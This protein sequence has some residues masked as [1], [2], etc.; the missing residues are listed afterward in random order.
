MGINATRICRTS[1]HPADSSRPERYFEFSCLG[2]A[3]NSPPRP[4]PP[5]PRRPQCPELVEADMGVVLRW[6]AFDPYPAAGDWVD[7][8]HRDDR[9]RPRLP[10]KGSGRW[11]RACHHDDV[12]LRADQLLRGR[13]YPIDVTAVA[14]R[15]K[16]QPHVAAIGPTQVRKRLRERRDARLRR[17]IV[18]VGC[19]EHAD[20]SHPVALLRARRPA[21]TPPCYRAPR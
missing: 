20:A 19:H 5:T 10:L 9:D 1:G 15:T 18:F 6:A 13:S 8:G 17:G 14:E 7:H 16:V 11:G 2:R 3:V 4:L 12:G 21:A